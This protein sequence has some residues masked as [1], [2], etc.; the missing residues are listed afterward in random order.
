ML[1]WDEWGLIG[2]K[3]SEE[4]LSLLDP[5]AALTL[6]AGETFPEGRSTYETTPGQKV[7]AAMKSYGP[8]VSE[9]LEVRLRG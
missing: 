6:S 5:G 3:Q 2:K 1:L 9:P 7:P 8:A 4:D